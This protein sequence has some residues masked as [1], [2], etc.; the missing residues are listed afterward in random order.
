MLAYAQDA[1]SHGL[2]RILGEGAPVANIDLVADPA[3]HF[4]VIM[5]DGARVKSVPRRGF[6]MAPG[7]T[8]ADRGAACSDQ[9][10]S[11]FEL[12]MASAR[13]CS[14]GAIQG[15]TG[16]KAMNCRSWRRCRPGDTWT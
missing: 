3:R 4:A 7:G 6:S 12:V 14:P 8:A 9:R 2:F 13:A 15:S 16:C 11:G 5:K 10:L 1:P